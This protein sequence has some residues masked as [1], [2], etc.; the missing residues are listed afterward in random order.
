MHTHTHTHS[1]TW[2]VR[3]LDAAYRDSREDAKN[4]RAHT[5]LSKHRLAGYRPEH[6][7]ICRHLS[8]PPFDHPLWTS[9]TCVYEHLCVCLCARVCVCVCLCV[10]QHRYND[11]VDLDSEVTVVAAESQSVYVDYEI[12]V[13]TKWCAFDNGYKLSFSNDCGS[14]SHSVTLKPEHAETVSAC[15]LAPNLTCCVH[16]F[17]VHAF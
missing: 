11:W 3:C 13:V 6:T 9:C 7:P 1:L 12:T 15:F 2:S 14:A 10:C 17:G 16:G 4:A 8:S 5:Q